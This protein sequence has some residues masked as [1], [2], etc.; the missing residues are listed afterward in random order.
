M[1][2]TCDAIMAGDLMTAMGAFTPDALNAAMALGSGLTAAPSLTGYTIEALTAPA[3]E[4]R[5]RVRFT[6][7][8][9]ELSAVATWQQIEGVWL[10][11]AIAL[12]APPG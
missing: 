11:T 7:T 3:G 5:F 8:E 12:E 9:K 6:T 10:I 4:Q 1:R 2:A